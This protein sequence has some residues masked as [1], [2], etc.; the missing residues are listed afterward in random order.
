MHGNNK[1]E[2]T[3]LVT[4]LILLYFFISQAVSLNTDFVLNV[5]ILEGVCRSQITAVK[6]MPPALVMRIEDLDEVTLNALE[7]CVHHAQV[8]EA[9][10]DLAPGH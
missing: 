2:V 8:R 4:I 10:F 6:P 1:F 7:M 9:L 5:D 3:Y